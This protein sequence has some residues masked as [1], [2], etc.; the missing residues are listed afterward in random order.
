MPAIVKELNGRSAG[1]NGRTRRYSVLG[2]GNELAAQAAVSAEAPLIVDLF[3]RTE[4]NVDEFPGVPGAWLAQVDYGFGS[5]SPP[6]MGVEPKTGDTPSF[7]FEIGV[8]SVRVLV[9]PKGGSITVYRPPDVYEEDAP[10]PHLIGDTGDPEEPPSGADVFEPHM[11]FT[12]T[13]YLDK[14]DVDDEY[15]ATCGDL[16]GKLNDETFVGF[17]AEEVLAIGVSGALRSIF[18]DWEITYRFAVKR[19]QTGLVIDDVTYDK[20]GWQYVW[21]ITQLVGLKSYN[22]QAKFIAVSDL[23]PKG[24]FSGFGIGT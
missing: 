14:E 9:P 1:I 4:I 18:D 8:Q 16:V 6:G 24:D 2:A 13:A 3:A 17:A 5:N 7:S 21:P 10:Q 20:K 23:Y 22:R 12:K 11:E 15:I 19:H